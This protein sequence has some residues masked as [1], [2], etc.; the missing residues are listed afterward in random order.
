MAFICVGIVAVPITTT[1]V[2]S[3]QHETRTEPTFGKVFTTT[4]T[5]ERTMSNPDDVLEALASLP[6]FHHPTATEDGDRVARYYDDTGRN[7]LHSETGERH[8]ASDGEVPRNARWGVEWSAD[9]DR[10]FFR[11]DEDGNEQNDV[12]AI[13]VDGPTAGE[14]EPVI[15]MDGQVS[16]ADVGDDG[17]T[18]LLG[19]TRD[20]QMNLYRHDLAADETEKIT[21]YERAAFGGL[22]SPDCE[23]IA[24]ATNEP[25][26][27]DNMDAYV[28]DSDGSNP[29]NLEIGET[30]AESAPADWGA[31]WRA[32][33]R[34]RQH[35]GRRALWRV[36]SRGRGT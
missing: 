33:A 23:R 35:R 16:L 29:R 24:Y 7:E 11:L 36:R 27:F 30:G 20:G 22:L 14:T 26:D 2:G 31:R 9:G 8:Q 6:S 21:D 4:W 10:V 15:E 13:D 32:P 18:L 5:H 3:I 25:D 34:L 12:H 17:D 19:S 1:V 28:A